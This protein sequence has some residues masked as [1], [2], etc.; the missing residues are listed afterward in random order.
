MTP[1]RRS[2]SS[3]A[4]ASVASSPLSDSSIERLTLWRLWV[5]EA[6]RKTLTSSKRSRISSARSSP[7]SFGIR[8]EKE[9]PSRRWAAISTW[10]ASASCG[11]T[12]GRTK[13]VTSIR[14][15]PVV[16]SM[17]I[18]RT[19]SAVSIVS[20]SFW[21]PSR[22]PTSRMRTV[23][24]KGGTAEAYA[25]A[26]PLFRDPKTS[27]DVAEDGAHVFRLVAHLLVGEAQRC[28]P[29]GDMGLV[30]QVVASLLG[31]SA[32]VA[33]AVGLD[34]QMQLWPQEVDLEAV[35]P[36]FRLRQWQADVPGQGQEK[37]LEVGASQT[38][39]AAVEPCAQA[40][41][42]PLARVALERGTKLRWGK[43]IE[44]VRLV[45]HA[46]HGQPIVAGR[47]VDQGLRRTRH[48]NA[49]V[50]ADILPP[51]A[52]AAVDPNPRPNPTPG[53]TAL[54]SRCDRCPQPR[55]QR[56]PL[57]CRD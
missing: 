5:S 9:T 17:S 53:R 13:E 11:I 34:D 38:E 28:E 15:T 21:N 51:E 37:A 55:S 18:S 44:P 27:R 50:E 46:L 16:E 2:P 25:A 49:V 56:A 54:K 45:D 36:D 6:E 23:F 41:D 20:G 22:G 33:Q 14:P 31:R 52:G 12:S 4:R 48:R 57:R 35:D 32:V 39:G 10:A 19:F 7:R 42:A 30:P 47:E 40:S 26:S 24:G 8:T 3:P 43:E 1:S 29:G